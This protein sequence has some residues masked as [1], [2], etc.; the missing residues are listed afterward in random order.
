VTPH[1]VPLTYFVP[2]PVH[3][4]SVDN[5]LL[6][7][8]MGDARLTMLYDLLHEQEAGDPFCGGGPVAYGEKVVE[9]EG[10]G[11]GAVTPVEAF[12]D[13]RCVLVRGEE[14]EVGP[15]A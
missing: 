9:G 11:E 10:G 1:P 12:Y 7:H 13:P 14:I 4:Q 15:P 8:C 5:C 2:G 6:L 3:L